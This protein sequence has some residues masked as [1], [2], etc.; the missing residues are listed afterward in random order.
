MKGS[1]NPGEPNCYDQRTFVHAA[2]FG[3]LER[4]HP[5]P[6]VFKLKDRC[7]IEHLVAKSNRIDVGT[8]GSYC[9]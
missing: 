1:D 4:Y 3:V 7:E 9:R 8:P 2:S 6:V 5:E